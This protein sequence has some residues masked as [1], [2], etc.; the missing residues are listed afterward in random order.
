MNKFTI[1]FLSADNYLD[2][3]T[4]WSTSL[5]RMY[6][7]I[8]SQGLKIVD[9]NSCKPTSRLN[10][11]FKYFTQNKQKNRIGSHTYFEKLQQF[12]RLIDEQLKQNP[13]DVIFAVDASKEI[14]FLETEIPIVYLSDITFK[15]YN[16]YHP[17]TFNADQIKLLDTQEGMAIAKA[18]KVIYPSEWAANSAI[19]DYD[20]GISKVE[21]IPFGANLDNIP[22]EEEIFTN[23]SNN[24]VCRLLFISEDWEQ[25]GGDIAIKTMFLLRELGINAKIT[26]IGSV[27]PIGI[28]YEPIEVIPFLDK[29]KE[30]DRERLYEILKISH[31]LVFPARTEFHSIVICEANAFGIPVIATEAGGIPTIIKNGKNGYMLPL[32]A[33]EIDFA[34]SIEQTFLDRYFYEQLRVSSRQEYTERLNWDK[35]GKQISRILLETAFSF[36]KNLRF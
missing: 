1:G 11:Y 36:S 30:S 3:N 26:I 27:P 19:Y 34:K 33:S 18:K 23:K 12:T 14:N 4:W 10:N 22:L 8:E 25:S 2:K 7:A 21:V 6:R 5:E 20:A 35:W 15:L 16:Q 31:F 29:N 28:N 17:I 32:S 13:C 9:L 24:S